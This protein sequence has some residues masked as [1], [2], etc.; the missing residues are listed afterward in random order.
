[1]KALPI[2]RRTI[3]LLAVVIPLLVLFVY[4][5]LRSGPLAPVAVTVGNVELQV[6]TPGLFGIG[7][8]EARHTYKIGPTFAGRIKRVEVQVGDAVRAGQLLGEM[9]PVDLDDRLLSLGST[10]KRA[11][12]GVREA[13][14]R[15]TYAANQMRRYAQLLAVRMTSEEAGATKRNELNIA[16]AALSAA[17]EEVL[18]ARSDH[19]ALLAQRRNLRLLAPVDGIVVSRDA[20]PGTTIVAGQSVIEVIDP[21][22]LWVNVRFNQSGAAGL[23]AGLPARV[24]LRSQ[25]KQ[26][27]PGRVLRV[28]PKADAITEETLAKLVFDTLPKTLPP[29]GELAEVTVDLP[30][31][32]KAPVI[33]NAALRRMGDRVGVWRLSS[34]TLAFVPVVLGAA[35]LNGLVQVR[36]GL[37][38]GDQIVVYSEKA[39][40]DRSRIKLVSHIPGVAK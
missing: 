8:V 15:Q 20:D 23:A 7:T 5:G 12:A 1:M 9:D 3:A 31:L 29:I 4:V 35:D 16:E 39:L 36:E 28:E 14:A 17:R 30:P 11:E 38:P 18:R 25:E 27:L 40:T 32:P 6:I 13:Q 19:N 10:T 21:K 2:Q 33:P 37:Q 34:N 22:T 24:V 26:G